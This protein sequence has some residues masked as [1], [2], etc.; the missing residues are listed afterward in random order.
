VATLTEADGAD[1]AMEWET[2]ERL[3]DAIV[4]DT[5][6]AV[7]AE[8]ATSSFIAFIIVEA[9]E[10]GKGERTDKDEQGWSWEL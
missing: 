1:A 4:D 5:D 9:I 3:A 10:R 6:V 2:V 8:T 7:V